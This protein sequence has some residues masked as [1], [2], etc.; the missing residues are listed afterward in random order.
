MPAETLKTC[1][2]CG[3]E[4]PV[5]EYYADKRCKAGLKTCCKVCY[6]A[7]QKTYNVDQTKRRERERRRNHSPGGRAAMARYQKT[8]KYRAAQKRFRDRNKEQ[9]AAE[10]Q[11]YY[12]LNRDEL[13][14]KRNAYYRA[15]PEKKRASRNPELQRQDRDRRRARLLNAFVEDVDFDVIL[16]RDLGICG[17]CQQQITDPYIELDHIHPLAAGGTHEPNNVQLAHRACNRRK[18][19]NAA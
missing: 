7:T 18:W 5:S 8:A 16:Q 6:R 1:A 2:K 11:A 15:H 10:W 4:K 9:I 17:I 13:R 19:M 12:K 3:A 14:A